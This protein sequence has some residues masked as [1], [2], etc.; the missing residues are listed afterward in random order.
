MP[1]L[2]SEIHSIFKQQFDKTQQEVGDSQNRQSARAQQDL[3][4]QLITHVFRE[5]QTVATGQ[6]S[7]LLLVIDADRQAIQ[8]SAPP[9]PSLTWQNTIA[10]EAAADLGIPLIDLTQAFTEDYEQHGEPF[11]FSMD[12]HWNEHAHAV[13]A[14]AVSQ[15]LVDHIFPPDDTH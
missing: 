6:G 1:R 15:W 14:K 3:V 10:N 12:Y 9:T 13:V 4:A 11:S 5:Y 7:E 8:Q 2:L